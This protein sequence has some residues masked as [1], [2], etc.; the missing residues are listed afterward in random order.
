MPRRYVAGSDEAVQNQL[1]ATVSAK[2]CSDP[3]RILAHA[4]AGLNLKTDLST[5]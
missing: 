2:I 1:S 5:V 3:R 4:V